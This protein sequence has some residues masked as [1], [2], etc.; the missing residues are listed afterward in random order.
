MESIDLS[1]GIGVVKKTSSKEC[2]IWHYQ[3]F[4]DVFKIKANVCNGYHDVIIMPM[5]RN[6]LVMLGIFGAD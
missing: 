2:I 1:E 6:G 5:D 4:L 3:Y